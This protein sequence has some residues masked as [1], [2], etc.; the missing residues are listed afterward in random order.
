MPWLPPDL[1]SLLIILRHDEFP[2]SREY[3]ELL[4]FV[5]KKR[6]TIIFWNDF[7]ARVRNVRGILISLGPSIERVGEIKFRG[8]G[9]GRGC[10]EVRKETRYPGRG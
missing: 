5:R 9:K 10:E 2:F 3:Q 8:A 4:K 1:E 7:E 6:L